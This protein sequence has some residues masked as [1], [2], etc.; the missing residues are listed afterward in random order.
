MRILLEV[1]L[2]IDPKH[3]DIVVECTGVEFRVY[4]DIG[5]VT[6]DVRIELN[7]VIYVPFAQSNSKVPSRVGFH[8]VRRCED[9]LRGDKGAAANVHA[10]GRV[11]LQNRNLPRVF[12]CESSRSIGRY[13]T[14]RFAPVSFLRAR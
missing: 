3:R 5:H 2:V 1:E 12:T 14:V 11:F 7:V 9:M 10:L 4:V 8:A 13:V 6:F